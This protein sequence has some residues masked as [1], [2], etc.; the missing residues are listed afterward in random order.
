ML[1]P[2]IKN[3]EVNRPK[4][5]TILV[6]LIGLVFSLGL[7]NWQQQQNDILSKADFLK[8]SDRLAEALRSRIDGYGTGLRGIR[9]LFSAHPETTRGA[10]AAFAS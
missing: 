10:F 2:L 9:G 5:I 7:M 6:M 1:S 3:L 4:L 8:H